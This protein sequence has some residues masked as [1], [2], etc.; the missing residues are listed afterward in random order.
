MDVVDNG[1][2]HDPQTSVIVVFIDKVIVGNI[3][4]YDIDWTS[5]AF[6]VVSISHTPSNIF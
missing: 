4:G 5:P 1:V 3:I 6:R 2:L